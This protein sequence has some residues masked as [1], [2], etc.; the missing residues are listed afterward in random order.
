MASVAGSTRRL[1][2][3]SLLAFLV[4]AVADVGVYF[5]HGSEVDREFTSMLWRTP[6]PLEA[7]RRERLLEPMSDPDPGQGWEAGLAKSIPIPS[8]FWP[9]NRYL[10]SKWETRGQKHPDV[11]KVLDSRKVLDFFVSGREADPEMLGFGV[12]D[13]NG[14]YFWDLQVP[15]DPSIVG[16]TA[17]GQTML[18]DA[19][20]P[21][22]ISVSNDVKMVVG[23]RG[24]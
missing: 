15:G 17:Y 23:N 21:G 7:E 6:V 14:I 8:Y 19:G 2:G 13:A 5:K 1:R 10:P 4:L 16:I 9:S 12:A 24:F 18:E 11:T 22:G 20:N 3:G